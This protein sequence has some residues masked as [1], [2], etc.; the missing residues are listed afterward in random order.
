MTMRVTIKN[1]DPGRVAT[2]AEETF[3][4]GEGPLPSSRSLTVLNPGGYQ[5][6]YI[7]ASKRLIVSED[8]DASIPKPPKP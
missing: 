5:S 8:P 4:P 3:T 7:H 2:V 1:E 6:F